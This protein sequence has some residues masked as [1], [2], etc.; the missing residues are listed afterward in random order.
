MDEAREPEDR[1]EHIVREA[2]QGA[3]FEFNPAAWDAMEQ[4]LDALD[5][6]PFSIWKILFPITG[7]AVLLMVLLWPIGAQDRQRASFEALE[8]GTDKTEQSLNTEE[9]A[10]PESANE[11]PVKSTADAGQE[12]DDTTE[13]EAINENLNQRPRRNTITQSSTANDPVAD[14]ARRA[15]NAQTA[16][17]VTTAEPTSSSTLTEEVSDKEYDLFGRSEMRETLSGV[18]MLTVRW[19]PNVI[20][21]PAF[22]QPFEVD[23]T[24]FKEGKPKPY[25]EKSRWAIS[26]MVSL[27]MSATGLDG[28]TDPGTMFGLGV[29]YYI[30]PNWSIQ[31]GA[32]IAVKKYTALGSEYDLPAWPD[33]QSAALE[34]V[35]A[36]CLVIDIPFNIRRYFQTKNGKRLFVSTGISSYLMLRETYNYEYTVNR[37]NWPNDREWRNQN[38]HYAGILNISFGYETSINKKLG[39]AVEPFAKLPLTGIGQGSVRFL[40]FGTV[41][42]IK[43]RK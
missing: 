38:N 26:A 29:E 32:A 43:L 25:F 23:S 16:G 22:D 41:V 4:K 13:P 30:A 6:V 5:P 18:D 2:E 3:Q 42:A 19:N 31:T 33:A 20:L 21:L 14:Q 1:I 11:E 10:Q 7:I 36:N 27:D 35:L 40:S 15:R 28:F 8:A 34:N 9:K 17:S 12:A 37:P 39:F 24:H